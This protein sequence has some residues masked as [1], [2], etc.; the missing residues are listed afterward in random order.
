M[1]DI[2]SEVGRALKMK[3]KGRD[4][5]PALIRALVLFDA[6]VSRLII[7]HPHR[8]KE[9]LRAKECFL[10]TLFI[11]GDPKIE[12]YSTQFAPAARMGF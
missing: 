10:D 5:E 12:N 2:G 11:K 8:A 9:V 1:G 3:R 4:F 6:T 7:T